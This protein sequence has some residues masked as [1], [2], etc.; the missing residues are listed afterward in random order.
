[1]KRTTISAGLAIY[2]ILS[3][4]EDL[5]SKVNGIF[6]VNTDEE[7]E[8]PFVAYRRTGT[9]ISEVKTSRGTIVGPEQT[10]IEVLCGAA[11]YSEAIELAEIAREAIEG[12]IYETRTAGGFAIQCGGLIDSDEFAEADGFF[13]SLIFNIK[14]R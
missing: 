9:S 2:E 13:I 8:F 1:M 4:C 7:V 11:S 10:T 6:P 12:R 5:A 3:E 14:M